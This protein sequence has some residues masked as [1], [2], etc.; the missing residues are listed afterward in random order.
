MTTCVNAVDVSTCIFCFKPL[1]LREKTFC[2]KCD[3]LVGMS[4]LDSDEAEIR[5]S[6]RAEGDFYPSRNNR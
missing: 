3:E 6:I 4:I 1:S 5:A 2:D